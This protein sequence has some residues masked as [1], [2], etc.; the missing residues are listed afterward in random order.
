MRCY[1]AHSVVT[2][3]PSQLLLSQSRPACFWLPSF[4]HWKHSRGAALPHLHGSLRS[5]GTSLASLYYCKID[6]SNGEQTGELKSH[7][8]AI[9]GAFNGVFQAGAFFGILIVSGIMDRYGRK[10]GVVFC[11]FWSIIGGTLLCA[12]QSYGMFIAARFFAGM[13]SWGFLAVT[14]TYSAELAPPKIRGLFVGLNG[15]MIA[16]GYGLASYMG[17]G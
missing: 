5:C 12:S 8:N 17:M 2:N 6:V 1:L 9:I 15:V 11:S 16:L 10:G 7:A 13:G 4:D 3:K 14:P